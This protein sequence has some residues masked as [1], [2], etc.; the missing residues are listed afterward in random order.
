MN[1]CI[2]SRT[3]RSNRGR[4]SPEM[5]G[6]VLEMIGGRSVVGL[7]VLL[8]RDFVEPVSWIARL[9]LPPPG[10]GAAEVSLKSDAA[11]EV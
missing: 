9:Q 4:F 7:V 8:C 1:S 2:H 6:S 11:R 3:G 5:N 10:P